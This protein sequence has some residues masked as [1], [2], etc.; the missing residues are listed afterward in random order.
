MRNL[1]LI[2]DCFP[3]LYECSRCGRAVQVVPQG[4]GVEPLK[5][6]SCGHDDAV[7]WANRKVTLR[8]KDA[9]DADPLRRAA[10]KLRLPVRQ[11]LSW[12]TGRSV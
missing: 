5:T 3:P 1:S 6:F 11:L 2:K 10:V 4:M 7:I 8:G 12:A 9:L